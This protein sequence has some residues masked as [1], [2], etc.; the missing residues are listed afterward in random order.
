MPVSA[1]QPLFASEGTAARL[2]DMKRPEF[3]RL[4]DT[5]ALPPPNALD[6]WDVEALIAAMTGQAARPEPGDFDL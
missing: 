2:L 6:R 5:G 3:R 4:V 1:I